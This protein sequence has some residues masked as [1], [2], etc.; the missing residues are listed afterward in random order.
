MALVDSDQS[1]GG[2]P[3]A[4]CND[5]CPLAASPFHRD[6][7]G[8]RAPRSRCPLCREDPSGPCTQHPHPGDEGESRADGSA[9]RPRPLSASAQQSGNQRTTL[10][11]SL[12]PCSPSW[13]PQTRSR[14]QCACWFHLHTCYTDKI[15]S[16]LTHDVPLKVLDPLGFKEALMGPLL[17]KNTFGKQFCNAAN[18]WRNLGCRLYSSLHLSRKWHR[19]CAILHQVREAISLYQSA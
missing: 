5:S 2:I 18:R 12:S 13:A 14:L 3:R 10:P 7:S 8:S 1:S 9:P 16:R 19:I 17:A 4:V 6:D 15:Q 11:H